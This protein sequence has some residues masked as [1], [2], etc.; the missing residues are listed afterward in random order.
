M[1]RNP[2]RGS[3]MMVTMIVVTSLLCGSSI[4]VGM[5][6][7]SN[8]SNDLARTGTS[9][10]YCAEAGLVAARSVVASNYA[11]WNS[12]L[13]SGT[14]PS[15]L[16]GI[17][18]DVDGD[19]VADFTITLKD[20]DDELPPLT[21][22]PTHDNDLKVFVVSTC[23]KYPDTP[24]QVMELVQYNGGGNC[25]QAQQGGCGGNGNSN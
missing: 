3:A 2:E 23:T 20:N 6:L 25:Y 24:K 8:R 4:L 14:E 18:H 10:L 1:K 9:A 17:N 15:W 21:N 5:Q 7:S 19:G 12:A 22:D 13:A 11:L 16:S